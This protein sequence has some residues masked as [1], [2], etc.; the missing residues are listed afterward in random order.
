MLYKGGL[1]QRLAWLKYTTKRKKISAPLLCNR[2][3]HKKNCW[4]NPK[5]HYTDQCTCYLPTWLYTENSLSSA[6]L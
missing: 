2:L 1:I 4:I 6:S 5:L 3:K